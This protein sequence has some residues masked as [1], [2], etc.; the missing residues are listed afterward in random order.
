ME[1]YP[2][3]LLLTEIPLGICA[4]TI[5][6]N[7]GSLKKNERNS[8]L[9][10]ILIPII[11]TII[12]LFLYGFSISTISND[13]AIFSIFLSYEMGY[14]DYMVS[15]EKRLLEQM[16]TAFAHA[17]DY[18]DTYTGG[19][20][21]R[22]ARYSSLI[23]ERMGKS[24]VYIEKLKQMA[25]LHDIGKIGIDDAILRKPTGLSEAEYHKIKKHTEKGSEILSYI[26]DM[27]ELTIGARWHH[28]R[29]DGKGY[30]DGLAGEEIPLAARIICVADSYDAMTS[31]RSY[32]KHL[33]QKT[34][35][36]E[37]E[38]NIGVQFDPEAARCMLD[39]IDEDKHFSLR[40]NAPVLT[41]KEPPLSAEENAT[42]VSMKEI[43]D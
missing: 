7:W 40:E 19:H 39:I 25:L 20:S 24:P 30:P 27:P 6:S 31:G 43:Y 22:V 15:K 36:A 38:R 9:L 5:F 2:S 10:F 17:I 18:K 14:S 32:R 26:T 28:E 13:I 35:R 23:A 29:Y 3:L 16:T 1:S 12:Q 41:L 11:G 34:V 42:V 4:G 21:V 8:F 33:D 37:I